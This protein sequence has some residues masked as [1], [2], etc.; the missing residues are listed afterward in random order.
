MDFWAYTLAYRVTG[1][2]FM[3][4]MARNIAR[5]NDFGD[6]GTTAQDEPQLD[7]RTNCPD[8]AALLGF[9]E[10]YKKTENSAYLNMA[11]KVG[12]NM[13]TGRFHKGYFVKS[14][15]HIY[16]KFDALEPLALL[17]LDSALKR[18]PI[19]VPKVWPGTSY[20]HCPYDGKGR[21]YDNNAIYSQI[22]P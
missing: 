5:G 1:D 20:F 2:G 6:I 18:K 3:W 10:L 8:V 16:V 4:E 22:A 9:L 15:K 11:K 21:T 7:V 13:L 12:D 14:E 19:L 17:H